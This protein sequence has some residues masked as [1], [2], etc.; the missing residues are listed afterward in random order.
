MSR[1]QV[2]AWIGGVL[3]GAAL[4]RFAGSASA[5]SVGDQTELSVPVQH[6]VQFRGLR[7]PTKNR[8]V[9]GRFGLM[10]KDL[11][12][13]E[14][15]DELLSGLA[16]SMEEPSQAQPE[17][18]DVFV[19]E[20]FP[21]GHVLLGQFIDHD[22]TFDN[23][24]L[25]EQQEDPLARTNFRSARFDLD[26]LYGVGPSV[27][28][29]LYDRDDP[30]KLRLTG[31][32]DPDT[33]D[34]LPRK[35]GGSEDGTAIIGDPRN[36]EN[37]IILQLHI[38]FAKFHNA[39][40]DHVRAQGGSSG[41]D[42]VF[43]KAQ[44]LCRWHYQWMVVHD[45]LP[46]VVG[47]A[48]VDAILK[49]RADAPA[50]VRLNYY[51]PQNPDK[52]MM[53]IEFAVAAYRFGHSMLRPTYV[54][55]EFRKEVEGGVVV[56]VR[57]ADIF[58]ERP[59]NFNLNGKRPCP[60]ELVIDWRFFFDIPGVD[61]PANA[62]RRNAAR[63]LDSDLSVPLFALPESIIPPPDRTHISLA[64]R[65]LLRGKRLGLPSGQ[66]VA[67][68]MGV[69]ALSNKQLEL[70]ADP[71]WEGQAPLWFYI[72]KEAEIQQRGE[73][74]GAVGGRIVAEVFLGL[75][76]LDRSSYLR[77][78]PPWRP[79]PPIAGAVGRFDM[80]NLLKFAGAA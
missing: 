66:R 51:H 38:A 61:P 42:E 20:R 17:E 64:E 22:L 45:F 58:G 53:P 24:P 65:N 69:E 12:A 31:L 67:R 78:D 43:D 48:R 37:L 47:Q 9:E 15:P 3:A 50:I 79:Q 33:P 40:V 26:S 13:F 32:A 72:L 18:T 23:T 21:A 39:L 59:T 56:D 5:A 35:S 11:P 34:D 76:K 7:L 80:G 19:P 44:R 4:G 70:G 54:I 55:N 41:V 36:D 63:K 27:S 8:S 6:G 25:P 30:A 10:F 28:P 49:E 73:R 77:Q 74:L 71:G 57:L 1:R 52:P 68:R 60:H 14:P 75:L 29:D 62:D 2:L 16:A 46:R